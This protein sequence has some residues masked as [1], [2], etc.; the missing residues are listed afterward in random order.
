M[1]ALVTPMRT[2]RLTL[3]L[4]CTVLLTALHQQ[5]SLSCNASE[6]VLEECRD[7]ALDPEEQVSLLQSKGGRGHALVRHII[8]EER[9]ERNR[10]QK[11]AD[12]E[13]EDVTNMSSAAS[14][15]VKELLKNRTNEEES[16]ELGTPD[17]ARLKKHSVV[18]KVREVLDNISAKLGDSNIPRV[19]KLEAAR[20][21]DGSSQE[22]K[23]KE[24]LG[25]GSVSNQTLDDVI[26]HRVSKAVDK[27]VHDDIVADGRLPSKKELDDAVKNELVHVWHIIAW[28]RRF[29]DRSGDVP[30]GIRNFFASGAYID[31]YLLLVAVA[32]FLALQRWL[33]HEFKSS[34]RFHSAVIAM[35]LL[36][37]AFYLGLII[38]RLGVESGKQWFTGYILELV[39]LIENVFVFHGIVEA[40]RVTRSTTQRNMFIV[41][42]GQ[43]VFQ[44]VFYMGLADLLRSLHVLPYILGSWLLCLGYQAST[45]DH[46]DTPD[47]TPRGTHEEP[48]AEAPRWRP[49]V[50]VCL[51]LLADFLLEID[52][53]LT[54]IESLPNQYICFSSSVAASF[55]LPDLFF[56]ARDLFHHFSG[57]KYGVCAI[58]IFFGVQMLLHEVFTLPVIVSVCVLV[59]II[60]FSILPDVLELAKHPD[61]DG[62]T[63]TQLHKENAQLRVEL[64]KERRRSVALEGRLQDPVRPA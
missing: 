19:G 6:P 64:E 30:V 61:P 41:V 34:R 50:L 51:L 60:V 26:S 57:L 38:A 1:C 37:G 55:L 28:S 35:W 59:S 46:I 11:A 10:T 4:L 9:V 14:E 16:A 43:I 33:L 2:D 20:E 18:P 63:V 52:V 25:N 45:S 29:G 32:V 42:I 15:L 58:L 3:C 17:E 53:A 44:M 24:E 31:W 39:F 54:K 22:K 8:P 47:V 23:L 36:L 48:H 7:P 49:E 5:H 27:K 12:K 40:F 56:V 13:D 21:A 62:R